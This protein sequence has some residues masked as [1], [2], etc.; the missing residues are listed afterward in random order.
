MP[1]TA[2]EQAELQVH[3][4]QLGANIRARLRF[5]E[6]TGAINVSTERGGEA[7][8]SVNDDILIIPKDMADAKAKIEAEIKRQRGVLEQGDPVPGARIP[9]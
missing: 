6:D 5:D 9:R 3:A 4:R 8:R 1:G 2:A 7:S